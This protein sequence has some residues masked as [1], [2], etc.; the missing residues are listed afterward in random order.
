MPP[1]PSLRTPRSARLLVWLALVPLLA[2]CAG[3]GRRDPY[4]LARRLPAD[5]GVVVGRLWNGMTYYIRANHEP[6]RRAELRLVV[7][8]GSILEDDDQRGLAHFVEH[9]AFNG[10]RGFAKNELVDWL[11]K[12]GM[13]FGPDINAY[14]SF[15]ETVYTLTLPTDTPRI[16]AT[17]LD[18]LEDWASGIVFDTAEVRKE[19][20]VV[21]EEWRLGR[22]AG[23]RMQDQQ[24]PVLF[25]RSRYARRVPIGDPETLR[26]FRV[27][28]LERFYRDWYR[29]D[30]M[31]VVAV[32]DFDARE[33]ERMIRSRFFS[34]LPVK[35]ARPRRVYPVPPSRETQFSVATDP[36]A[37]G[38]SVTL[39]HKVPARTRA[40]VRDYRDG[41]VESLY[42][43][44]MSDRLN[45]LTQR[46]DAPFLGVSSFSG[47]LVRPVDAYM[48][49]AEVADGGAARGLAALL[50]EAQRVARHGFT[51]G[52]LAREKADL[53]RSWEQ[54][55]AERAKATSAQFAGQYVGHFLYGGPLLAEDTEYEL[56]RRL[57]EGIALDEVNARARAW[58]RVPD[59]TVLV[60]APRKPGLAPPSRERLLAVVDSVS[61]LV[62]APYAETL[63][64]APLVE[65]PPTA[66]RVVSE[67]AVPEAGVTEWTLANG[68]RVVIR[69]TDF[70][71][72]EI[73]MVGRSPGGTSLVPDENYLAA[74]TATA[75][76]QVGGVGGLSVV[77]LQKRLAGK[78][79]SVGTDIS[80][81]QEGISGFAAPRDLETM[82]ELVYLY[83]TA[84]RRDSAAWEAYRE[85]ARE[86]LRNRGASPEA[87]FV[88]TLTRLL[89]RDD[90]RSRPLTAAAFD[91]ASL[92]RA[93]AV[94]RDRFADAGDFTF[95]FVGNVDTVAL[96][97]LAERWLGGLPSHGR[98]ESWRDRGVDPPP[99]VVRATVRRGLEPKGRTQIV[100][101][102]PVQFGRE[103]V[104]SL[105]A[106]SALLEIRLRE[107]LREDLGGTY[108]VG[109]AASVVRD[110]EPRYRFAVDFG[111]APER[112]DELVRVV[113][114]EI[115]SLGR[116][117][118]TQD[119]LAKVREEQRRQRE[120]DLRD[121]NWWLMQLLAYD[122][123]GWDL[124]G[125]AAPADPGAVTAERIRDAAR[126]YLDPQR[127]VQVSLVP[128]DVAPPAP[129]VPA[130]RP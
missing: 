31:A 64:D 11:E 91:T 121:N 102:G 106:L 13:R 45:E 54:I 49:S 87:A 27:R 20:G 117:G 42:S 109:V 85:R 114:S 118:P 61:R 115:A 8:A 19:R 127:Y 81:L 74:R 90:P 50:A 63:S 48:L 5:T 79:A 23:A 83:F 40:T 56:H 130:R 41:I 100:F 105:R 32:G 38:S 86:S 10:T 53:L 33:M 97:P 103:A 94:Y 119:E 30:L 60:N 47:T 98:R 4:A 16:L 67:R 71:E 14:T 110:P 126:L 76:A 29:P 82:M 44:L 122:N 37:T 92:D 39:V 9:M 2:A 58:L 112:L 21:T 55:H 66:G 107:R 99:G 111:A 3:A 120:L 116:A 57:L 88:D 101:H 104:V 35:N 78:A 36:E 84:P 46:P 12:A 69:P 22:G 28:E 73:L 26:T 128:E 15:D 72:D 1:L 80:E 68:V 24:L 125:I 113:F 108:G 17:G 75:A 6:R 93:L 34:V 59:R 43:G 96:R 65:H 25:R 18:V 7:N 124:A 51:E 70:R 89:T 62:P 123:N 77:D 129:R 52:E 95:F